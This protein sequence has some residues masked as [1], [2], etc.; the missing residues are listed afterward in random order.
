MVGKEEE[1]STGL[2][3][4]IVII[5]SGMYVSHLRYGILIDLATKDSNGNMLPKATSK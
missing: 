2:K 4:K 5:G 3:V 1:K